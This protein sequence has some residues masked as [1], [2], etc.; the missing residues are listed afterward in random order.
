MTWNDPKSKG[1][2][3]KNFCHAEQILAVKE[4]GGLSQSVKKVK[5]ATKTF[6]SDN[7]EGSSKNLSEIISTNVKANPNNT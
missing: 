1:A 6:F 5:F 2:S 7:V 4:V 3:T